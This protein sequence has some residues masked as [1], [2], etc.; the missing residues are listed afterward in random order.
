M[1]WLPGQH[2]GIV[3]LS[4]LRLS[5]GLILSKFC[6]CGLRPTPVSGTKRGNSPCP[7]LPACLSRAARVCW[8]VCSGARRGS[9][10]T[11]VSERWASFLHVPAVPLQRSQHLGIT[12]ETSMGNPQHMLNLDPNRLAWQLC[13]PLLRLLRPT[14][15]TSLRLTF[16][17]RRST[18][19]LLGKVLRPH[20]T[21]HSTDIW[22]GLQGSPRHPSPSSPPQHWGPAPACAFPKQL[23]S[24]V[25]SALS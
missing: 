15:H 4:F 13:P 9:A 16:L 8:E 25:L 20:P 1:Q 23:A 5:L 11:S 21:S 24:S 7:Q 22:M 10:C 12:G 19:P 2:W 3:P 6:L 14:F 17:T 18:T